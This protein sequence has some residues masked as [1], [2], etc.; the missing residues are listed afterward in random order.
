MQEEYKNLI[1]AIILQAL[2]DLRWAVSCM[3][4]N[5]A[6]YWSLRTVKEIETFFRSDWFALLCSFDGEWIFNKAMEMLK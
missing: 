5:P 3:K 4:K 6:D 2:K 1:A